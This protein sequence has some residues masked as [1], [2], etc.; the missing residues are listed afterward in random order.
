MLPVHETKELNVHFLDTKV[1]FL[2]LLF[3]FQSLRLCRQRQVF[4]VMFYATASV[5]AEQWVEAGGC[6][7]D[8]TSFGKNS[9]SNLLFSSGQSIVYGLI[10]VI[11][12]EP[13]DTL[14]SP[15]GHML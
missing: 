4:E 14:L 8:Q 7:F 2:S 9:S 5:S 11:R 3:D 10:T 1:Q 13:V 15:S 6:C 12:D